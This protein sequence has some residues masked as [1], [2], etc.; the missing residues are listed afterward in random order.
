VAG[1]PSIAQ[2]WLRPSQTAGL[3][4]PKPPNGPWWWFDHP[5]RAKKNLKFFLENG[6]GPWGWPIHPQGPRSHPHWTARGGP[7]GQN[8]FLK[9][10][11]LNFFLL[12]R[13]IQPPPRAM[14]EAEATL[15]GRLGVASKSPPWPLEVVR[16]KTI[17]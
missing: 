7:K 9:K 11:L 17:F 15:I 14:G 12:L 8:H 13:V 3:G 5:P 6:F 4:W 10:K 2:G 16:A 1:H